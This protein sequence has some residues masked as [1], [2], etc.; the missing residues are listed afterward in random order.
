MSPAGDRVC[1]ESRPCTTIAGRGRIL[2]RIPVNLDMGILGT[3]GK[4]FAKM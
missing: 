4:R 1:A 2:R 3:I